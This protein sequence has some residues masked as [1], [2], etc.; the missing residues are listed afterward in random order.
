MVLTCIVL[1]CMYNTKYMNNSLLFNLLQYIYKLKQMATRNF[2]R[3]VCFF[4]FLLFPTPTY[5]SG[6]H[7]PYRGTSC[8]IDQE[9]KKRKKIKKEIKNITVPGANSIQVRSTCLYVCMYSTRQEV[10]SFITPFWPCIFV[11][12]E[13]TSWRVEYV[14]YICKLEYIRI[15]S[16]SAPFLAGWIFRQDRFPAHYCVWVFICNHMCV[17]MQ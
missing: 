13:L 8:M 4:F 2:L 5:I 9:Q 3:G 10:S 12:N 15:H 7:Y 17:C 6:L 1:Y 11:K 14:Q 16:C